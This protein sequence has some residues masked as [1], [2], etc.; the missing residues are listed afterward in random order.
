MKPLRMILCVTLAAAAAGAQADTV[1]GR[2]GRV[3]DGDSFFV[4]AGTARYE[5]RIAAIDAPEHSQPYS[6][7]ARDHITRLMRGRFIVVDY[8]RRDRYGRLLGTVSADGVDVGLEQLAAGLAWHETRYLAEQAPQLAQ[9]YAAAQARA[10]AERRGLWR[11]ARPTPPWEWRRR[12][13][14]GASFDAS[15]MHPRN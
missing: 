5:V 7:V 9:R 4:V 14:R 3:M 11:Q 1:S 8:Y 6:R 2:L 13:P 15:P 10:R 12:H